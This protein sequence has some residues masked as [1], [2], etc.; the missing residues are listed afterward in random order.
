M[1]HLVVPNMANSSSFQPQTT[2]I[3]KRPWPIWSTVAICL[4]ATTGCISGTCT[5]AKTLMRF[6][7]A[8]RPAAQVIDSHASPLGLLSP[9]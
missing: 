7:A 6:V 4:A 5:V 8:S 1:L 9:P 3:P 2:L